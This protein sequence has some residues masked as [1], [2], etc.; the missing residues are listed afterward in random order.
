M[1]YYNM[2]EELYEN[3]CDA[4][5]IKDSIDFT[6]GDGT[7]AIAHIKACRKTPKGYV[8]ICFTDFHKDSLWEHL[9]HRTLELFATPSDPLFHPQYA[10]GVK[11]HGE[12]PVPNF[13]DLKEPKWHEG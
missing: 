4:L 7:N 6:P 9:C 5:N 11:K 12:D 2:P 1:T 10:A 13:I 3:T 8:G